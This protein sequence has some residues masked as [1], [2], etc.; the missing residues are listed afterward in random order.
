MQPR[1]AV[2]PASDDPAVSHVLDWVRPDEGR[3][4]GRIYTDPDV[5]DLELRKIW[6]RTWLY[7]GHASEVPK[8]GD[9][10]TRVVGRVPLILC[11]RSNGSVGVYINQCIHRGSLVCN[12]EQGSTNLFQCPYHGWSYDTDGK[13]R[14][15]PYASAYGSDFDK[16]NRGLPQPR[17]VDEYRGFIFVSYSD[18]GPPLDKHL[19]NAQEPLDRFIDLSPSGNVR[20]DAGCNRHRVEA[21]WK[22]FVENTSDN[23]HGL[24]VHPTAFDDEQ[25]RLFYAIARDAS[26]AIVRSL[27]NGHTELDFRPEN[28]VQGVVART[29]QANETQDAATVAYMAALRERLGPEAADILVRDGEPLVYIFPNLLVIQQDVRRLEPVSATSSVLH[30]YPAMLDGAPD[31]IN[32]QRL[33]RHETAYG[34]AGAIIPDDI[35]IFGRAQRSFNGDPDGW[36]T[37][38]RGLHRE[39]P[40]DDGTVVSHV[41]DET[42]MRGMWRQYLEYVTG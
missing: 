39:R 19:G 6:H 12:Y 3:V 2:L 24:F 1:T 23:Y 36:T 37:I 42:G 41:T 25:R 30:Q 11:R 20:L 7:A 10:V 28:R 22:I 29:G 32:E 16:S 4:F 14:N 27:D 18:D 26:K 40:A 38:T 35:E 31:E 5:F 13:L 21:N 33:A 15:I 8:A 9:Y 17:K 34:P